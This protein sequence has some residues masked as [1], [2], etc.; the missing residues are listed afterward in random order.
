MP[1]KFFTGQVVA[2]IVAGL[3][4]TG[5]VVGGGY[6]VWRHEQSQA[7]PVAEVKIDKEG[8]NLASN[9]L[10]SKF[11][12]VDSN[13]KKKNS[14]TT[15]SSTVA[16][17]QALP[18]TVATVPVP[19]PTPAQPVQQY[20]QF[21]P[22][23]LPANQDTQTVPQNSDIQPAPDNSAIAP[24]NSTEPTPPPQ[25]APASAPVPEPIQIAISE[26]SAGT[27]ANGS[28]DEFVELYNP[29]NSEIDLAGWALKKKT[30]TGTDYNL[31][32]ASAF[33]GKIKP[34]NFF[35]VTHKNYKGSVAA[36]L[37]YSANSNDL[38]YT[39][40]SVVIYSPNGSIMDQA[41]WTAIQKDQ[42]WE[43][44]NY[45]GDFHAEPN[46]NPQNSQSPTI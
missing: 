44:Q 23:E 16:I 6:S 39:N 2:K 30:S 36:D 42:S 33:I 45:T 14:K 24:I 38:S 28:E 37:I 11:K 3:A 1:G 29:T 40:N 34:H 26:V 25:P 43:R 27:T 13:P 20:Q 5:F 35:L 10:S 19:E 15:K 21:Q 41:T 22:T 4:V 31:V 9:V 8:A 17:N 7:Q 32:S 18:P 46:P 12:V